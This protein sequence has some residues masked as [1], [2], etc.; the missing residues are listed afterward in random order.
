MDTH[1]LLILGASVSLALAVLAAIVALRSRQ[2]RRQLV[3]GSLAV[4]LALASVAGFIAP[5][6]RSA[7]VSDA[8]TLYLQGTQSVYA[9]RATDGS[10]RWERP[11]LNLSSVQRQSTLVRAGVGYAYSF[12]PGDVTNPN[13]IPYTLIALRLTDGAELWHVRIL[14]QCCSFPLTAI[15]GDEIAIVGYDVGNGS[16]VNTRLTL[17]RASDGATVRSI[18]LQGTGFF[19]FDD[20]LAHECQRGGALV[21]IRLSDGRQI[22]SLAAD[23]VSSAHGP[24]SPT[25]T[26]MVADGVVYAFTSCFGCYPGVTVSSKLIAVRASDGGVLW[27]YGPAPVEY[28]TESG[29]VVILVAVGRQPNQGIA[30]RAS[31]GSFLW[32]HPNSLEGP[33]PFYV[34]GGVAYIGGG[35]LDAVRVS[36]G[37]LLWRRQESNRDFGVYGVVDGVLFAVSQLTPSRGLFIPLP[38]EDRTIHE[39]ALRATDGG[40]YWQVAAR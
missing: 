32:Q 25:C 2:R 26:P 33:L 27:R 37:S 19:A 20:N 31:D 8:L 11:A 29:G 35:T 9:L 30:L 4:V 12:R 38:W 10:L 1:F 36:D 40:V 34:S 16:A 3:A 18:L 22:W 23:I 24:V 21:A 7:P 17:L 15:V 5:S 39:Y 13:S 14:S 28:P 6:N